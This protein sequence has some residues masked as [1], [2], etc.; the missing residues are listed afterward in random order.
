MQ[1][2]LVFRAG[3]QVMRLDLHVHTEVSHDCRTPLRAIPAWM[4]QTNTRVIAVTDHDQ[5]RGGPEL[6][7]IVAD[8]G[9]ENRLSII[10]GEEV[11]TSEGELSALFLQQAIPKGL[12]PEETVREIRAQGGLVML[13]HGFDPLKRYRLRPEATQRI[14]DEIDIVEVFNSRLSRHH[15]NGVALAWAR[16]RGLPVCAGSDAHTLH[17]IG[18]AWVETPF[19]TVRTPTDLLE[20][21]RDGV[22][23]GHWTHPVYAYGRK[24]WRTLNGRFRRPAQP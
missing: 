23:A 3:V 10:P 20:A 13:Q 16:E 22:V 11:T 24:Q 15:W 18:E 6:A 1:N 12:T 4:L 14:A 19:R 9:L 17:D 8:L 5:Q 21:L 7:R 2:N